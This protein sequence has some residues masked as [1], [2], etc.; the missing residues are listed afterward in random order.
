MS[1]SAYVLFFVVYDSCKMT[2]AGITHLQTQG[3]EKILPLG[4][5]SPEEEQLVK[6]ALPELKKNIEKGKQFV[7]GA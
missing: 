6:E 3:V 7:K 2:D 4:A 1:N 5:L